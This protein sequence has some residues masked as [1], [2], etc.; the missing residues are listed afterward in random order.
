MEP[1]LNT[2]FQIL[3]KSHSLANS[4]RVAAFPLQVCDVTLPILTSAEIPQL[5]PSVPP[6][7]LLSR[8]LQFTASLLAASHED[9]S[10]KSPSRPSPRRQVGKGHVRCEGGGRSRHFPAVRQGPLAHLLAVFLVAPLLPLSS[11]MDPHCSWDPWKAA[12]AHLDWSLPRKYLKSAFA[13][14]D[15][16]VI[17]KNIE[18]GF[19]FL[20]P[21]MSR[22]MTL[23]FRKGKR[24]RKAFRRV[25]HSSP[26]RFSI[27]GGFRPRFYFAHAL[28]W[29]QF[30]AFLAD[31][32]VML[33]LFPPEVTPASVT[34]LREQVA[35]LALSSLGQSEKSVS[36]VRREGAPEK[37]AAGGGADPRAAGLG[38]LRRR[39]PRRPR[40][41]PAPPPPGRCR[42][43]ASSG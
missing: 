5:P 13:D 30:E 41:R 28:I 33:V 1:A 14:G 9:D 32:D 26:S 39:R 19:S 25:G 22:V 10:A 37:D 21:R 17:L 38:A 40:R 27:Q 23:S 15:V 18:K 43:A 2:T 7:E 4:A 31:A 34:L 8:A 36:S 35:P 12:E 11:R 6:R 29:Q 3:G 42:R 24:G 20:L 16:A